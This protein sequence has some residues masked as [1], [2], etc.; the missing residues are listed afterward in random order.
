[1]ESFFGNTF[2]IAVVSIS[3]VLFCFGI[4]WIFSRK[5]NLSNIIKVTADGKEVPQD[6][7][8]IRV[9]VHD[10]M[11]ISFHALVFKSVAISCSAIGFILTFFF[12][13][14]FTSIGDLKTEIKN[15]KKEIKNA[16][17]INDSL[18]NQFKTLASKQ[19]G[20]EKSIEKKES[21][22]EVILAEYKTKLKKNLDTAYSKFA[23]DHVTSFENL[24]NSKYNSKKSLINTIQKSL[25]TKEKALKETKTKFTNILKNNEVILK[26]LQ[27]TQPL[28][29][30][31]LDP[32][33]M[34]SSF[35]TGKSK[36]SK[37]NYPFNSFFD[38]IIKSTFKNEFNIVFDK[39]FTLHQS[40]KIEMDKAYPL[41]FLAF[42]LKNLNGLS[43]KNNV[44]FNEAE[45]FLFTN[46]Q[47]DFF[48]LLRA[49]CLIE[50]DIGTRDFKEA[51]NIIS[52]LE[53]QRGKQWASFLNFLKGR[54][55]A[56]TINQYH[57]KVALADSLL[58]NAISSY[59]PPYVKKAAE[60]SKSLILPL[61][62]KGNVI[63]DPNNVPPSYTD[64]I[65]KATVIS[66]L[67]IKVKEKRINKYIKDD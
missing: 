27:N 64:I 47:N 43:N 61:D 25:E 12:A 45:R 67:E 65:Q 57:N 5:K 42:Y 37:D 17:D 13:L 7:Q 41:Y 32:E 22:Y 33:E 18:T 16:E 4:Y 26:E 56:L 15:L 60:R 3:I 58:S 51:H 28:M 62:E 23:P 9:F 66:A 34:Y 29:H 63:K 30:S 8:G 38:D 31:N 11:L 24:L 21:K 46:F 6:E 36:F 52:R 39:I 55:Y 35:M 54:M 49:A 48:E 53:I 14:Q 1:M 59:L 44:I 10:K 50:R 40:E 2:V 19:E 20:L